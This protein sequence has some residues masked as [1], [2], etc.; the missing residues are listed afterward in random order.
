LFSDKKLNLKEGTPALILQK[1][2]EEK[3]TLDPEDKDLLVM[4]H[5]FI[6]KMDGQQ[7]KKTSSMSY[8]GKNQQQTAMA[9]TV[10]LPL[11]IVAK[12]ILQAKIDLTGV[13]IPIASQI[14]EPVLKELEELGIYF[15]ER[16][17]VCE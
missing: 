6:Y 9:Y 8:E 11:A 2:L 1:I 7:F 5:Q 13:Q 4:Q 3:W 10:G 15:T 14:Y 12:L 17:E 16:E